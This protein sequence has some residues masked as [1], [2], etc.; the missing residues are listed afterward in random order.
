MKNTSKNDW[1]LIRTLKTG[2]RHYQWF[3]GIQILLKA[4]LALFPLTVYVLSYTCDESTPDQRSHHFL[5]QSQQ[6]TKHVQWSNT[7]YLMIHLQNN[8]STRPVWV[9]KCD[10]VAFH[11]TQV[12]TNTTTPM[13][14]IQ[15]KDDF[16]EFLF[17]FW[18][19]C[20]QN[21]IFLLVAFTTSFY[22]T[23]VT[24]SSCRGL[25]LFFC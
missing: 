11:G 21:I 5:T 8:F 20:L 9:S 13:V 22:S 17:L 10:N 12:V 14:V 7:H 6:S 16:T 2:L 15:W 4:I 25:A 19:C 18:C 1:Y 3:I 24:R 23:T